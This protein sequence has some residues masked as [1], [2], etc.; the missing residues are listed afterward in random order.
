MSIKITATAS[1]NPAPTQVAGEN[2]VNGDFTIN[3]NRFKDLSDPENPI[4]RYSYI[5]GDGIDEETTWTFYFNDFEPG[6]KN[7][8]SR[9]SPSNTLTSAIFTLTLIPKDG[10]TA[11]GVPQGT[12]RGIGTDAVWIE[13]LTKIEIKDVVDL[14]TE[15]LNDVPNDITIDL[16]KF[17]D[18]K[19]ILNILFSNVGGRILMRYNDDAIITF[20]QLELI[21]DS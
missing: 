20:A 1:G 2:V 10:V 5:T 7:D 17:Y 4:D 8:F 14:N 13:T 16:L 3:Y 12:D 11:I 6:G 15:L 21:Q 19:D 18:P 9:L